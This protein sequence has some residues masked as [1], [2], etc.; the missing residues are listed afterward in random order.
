MSDKATWTFL[1]DLFSNFIIE[2]SEGRSFNFL[3][4]LVQNIRFSS[5][6][7]ENSLFSNEIF[8]CAVLSERKIYTNKNN[9][10]KYF[11]QN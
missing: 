4:C 7:F 11:I 6:K 3:F 8:R 10:I 1:R 9:Q 2:N 5:L